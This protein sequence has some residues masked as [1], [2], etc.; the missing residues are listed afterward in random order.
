MRPN[1]AFLAFAAFGGACFGW[2]AQAEGAPVDWVQA[3]ESAQS[4]NS[5]EYLLDCWASQWPGAVK[6][7][8]GPSAATSEEIKAAI[9]A[10]RERCAIHIKVRLD[11]INVDLARKGLL[12]AQIETAAPQQLQTEL[13]EM[14]G[15][16]WSR[17]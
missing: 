12:P 9:Q 14:F 7:F 17:L 6:P 5:Y 13:D 16:F 10:T 15:E 4:D 11:Q 3:Y 1:Q 2:S 8:E